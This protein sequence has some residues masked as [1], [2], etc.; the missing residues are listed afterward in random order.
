MQV[1]YRL[2]ITQA[3]VERECYMKT[4]KGIEVQSDTE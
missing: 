3:P 4:P 1:D 2:Y